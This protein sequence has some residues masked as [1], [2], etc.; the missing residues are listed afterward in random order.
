MKLET[1]SSGNLKRKTITVVTTVSLACLLTYL[2]IHV[3]ENCR[4]ALFILIPL[5]IGIAS[6]VL[7]GF[8]RG[9]QEEEAQTIGFLSL[10]SW[11]AAIALVDIKGMIYL[12]LFIPPGLVFTSIGSLLGH[13][14]VTKASGNG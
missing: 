2:G 10:A 6:S 5:F 13:F 12:F 1:G 7:Y 14:I 8:K 9:L 11:L 3:I 4:P